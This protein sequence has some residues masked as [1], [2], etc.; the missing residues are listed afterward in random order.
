[1]FRNCLKFH[2]KGSEFYNHGKSLEEFLDSFLEQWL[3]DLA[4]ETYETMSKPTFNPL[5]STS[6]IGKKRKKKHSSDDDKSE[7]ERKKHKKLKKEKKKH[8]KSKKLKIGRSRRSDNIK[9][10]IND[11]DPEEESE[12]ES[13]IEDNL[14]DMS[15]TEQLDNLDDLEIF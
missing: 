9:D 14:S 8:K 5:P 1:M 11:G 7:S 2:D 12:E 3:P 4:Y 13:P 6:G 15:N 10:F